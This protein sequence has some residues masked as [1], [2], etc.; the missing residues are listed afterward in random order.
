MNTRRKKIR[1]LVRTAKRAIGLF[2]IRGYNASYYGPKLTGCATDLTYEFAVK[3]S[4]GDFI[5]SFLDSL[6][7]TYSFIDIGANI[8]LFSLVAS[9][10]FTDGMVYSFEPNNRTYHF[11]VK[12]ILL[13]QKSNIVPICAGVAERNL[14]TK[15]LSLS[16][17]HSGISSYSRLSDHTTLTLSVNRRFL[18]LLPDTAYVA[19]IDVEGYEH[20]VIE[21]LL[22]SS[23]HVAFIIVEISP[24]RDPVS[25]KTSLNILSSNGFVLHSASRQSGHRDEI[26]K[27]EI[28][29]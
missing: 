13:N 16:K 4:Y 12:N 9:D 25:V 28:R 6:P 5:K 11:L 22:K 7:G 8:G 27:K 29:E 18:S 26:W 17:F 21:E 24:D 14:A 3:G 19:K 20:V 23:L 2:S 1:E 10:I 15:H